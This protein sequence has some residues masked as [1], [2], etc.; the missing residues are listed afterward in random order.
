MF[1]LLGLSCNKLGQY[2]CLRCKICF[3]EDHVR[4]KGVKYDNRQKLP[5]PKCGFDTEETKQLSMSTRSHKY[6][7]QQ[8][9]YV[10]EEEDEA[11]GGP[12]AS[13]G[14]YEFDD[15]DDIDDDDDDEEDEDESEDSEDDNN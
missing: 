4:R 11:T 13:Y 9:A 10:Y 15:E 1:T 12:S 7:R 14:D 5:C 6:G 3:C 2:S 8:G